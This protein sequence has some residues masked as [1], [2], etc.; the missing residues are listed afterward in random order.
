MYIYSVTIDSREFTVK[1]Y[2]SYQVHKGIVR[3]ICMEEDKTS[4]TIYSV[5][6][7]HRIAIMQLDKK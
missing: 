6:T 7:D 3:G 1:Y 5:G 4:L 2:G